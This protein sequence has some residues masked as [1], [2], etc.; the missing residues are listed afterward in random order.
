MQKLQAEFER[1]GQPD[2]F[3]LHG[4]YGELHLPP[5]EHRLWSPHL[6]F[7]V[8]ERE[9][10]GLIHGRF[11]PRMEVWTFVWI[12]YLAMSFTTFYGFTLAY[13][14]WMLGERGWGLWVAGGALLAIA[15]LYIVAHV[16]QQWSSDQM[17]LLRQRLEAILQA[18]GVPLSRVDAPQ[19]A[20]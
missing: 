15:V 13:S 2:S 14:Q 3:F 7:Y 5:S 12:V 19:S 9:E 16:G 1:V 10:Q 18:A 6:S 17:S 8:S 11:A 4:E 20:S